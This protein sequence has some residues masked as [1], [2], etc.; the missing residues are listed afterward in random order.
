MT[1]GS[2]SRRGATGTSLVSGCAARSD[3]RALVAFFVLAYALSWAWVGPL[4]VSHLVVDRGQ[5]WPTHYP[6]LFGPA[7]AAVLVVAG[8]TGRQG[9]AQLLQR[10][11]L[12]RVGWRWWLAAVSPVLFLAIA[13]LGSWVS[14]ASLP[15][16]T[17]FA[18][19]S[20]VPAVGLLGVVPLII[21]GAFGEEIGWRGFALP[22]LQHRFSPL[23]ASLILAA[24]WAL[25]H[26]PQFFVIATY[27]ALGVADYVGF[28]VGLSCGAIVLTWLYNRSGGSI[29][30]VAVWHGVY[31]V[32]S[33]TQAATGVVAA[34]VTTLIMAQALVLVGLVLRA[35]HRGQLPPLSATPPVR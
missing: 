22:H 10:I 29:L 34:V 3:G 30:L 1:L 8:T 24:L 20:G 28:V 7:V 33:G 32:V 18:L 25:W 35:R 12:W 16:P 27:R 17:D 31:N 9:I 21:V 26:L 4:A 13:L 15:G 19:F 23:M 6:A 11:V 14:G 2:A 5:G